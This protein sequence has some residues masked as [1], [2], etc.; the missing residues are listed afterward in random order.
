MTV[1]RRVD[2]SAKQEWKDRQMS[3]G[4]LREIKHNYDIQ[5]L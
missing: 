4:V 2:K 3:T 1:R 5:T